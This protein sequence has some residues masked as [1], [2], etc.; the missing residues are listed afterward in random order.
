M[1]ILTRMSPGTLPASVRLALVA[2]AFMAAPQ[3]V[4]ADGFIVPSPPPHVTEVVPDLAV[5]YHHVE[6]T[7]KDQVAETQIDQVFVNDSAYELEGTYIFPLPEDAAIS[8]FA[9]FVDGRKW[10]GRVLDRDQARRIYEDI[11]RRRRDP[12]LLEYAG[13]DAFQASI[14]PIEPFGEKRVQLSYSQVLLSEDGLVRYVYPLST[15]QFSSRPLEEVVITIELESQIPIKAIYSPSHSIAVER[16]GERSALISFEASDVRPDEDFELYY[17][18]SEDDVS[19]S[20]LSYKERGEDGF[21]LLLIAPR[22][23]IREQAIVAKDVVFVLDTSGSMEGKKL[24]QAQEALQFVLDHLNDND[25]FNIIAFDTGVSKYASRLQPVSERQSAARF[26]RGLSAGGGTNIHRALLEAMEMDGGRRP[27]F[28]IFLTDGLPTAG[29]TDLNEIIAEVARTAPENLRLFAFGLGYDVNTVLLDTISQEHRG[30]SA[31]VEPGQSIEQEVSAFYTKI[32]SPLLSDVHL[33]VDGVVVED[34]YPYPLP[35]LFAGGQLLVAGRYR[36]G[37]K[38]SVTLEGMVNDQ[39]RRMSYPTVR[40]VSDGGSSFVPRLWATRKI[41]H[42]LQQIRLHG[43]NSELVDE[44]VSLSVRYGIMTPYTSF[45]VDES[46]DI[47]TEAG[48]QAVA[49]HSE[50]ATPMAMPQSGAKAVADSQLQSNLAES[51]RSDTASASEIAIV[52]SK[53]FVTRE[54]IWT[55]TTY[56]PDTMRPRQIAFGSP[57]YFKLLANHPEWGKYFAVGEQVIVV[58]DGVAHQVHPAQ[59]GNASPPVP[60][61]APDRWE[62]FV[63]WL[64]AI[65]K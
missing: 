12:A 62:D 50:L 16:S 52:A 7:I 5:K 35:D 47:L 27:Q 1:K 10:D 40:L 3:R 53:T 37:G 41:G 60:S 17:S 20:L 38:A 15:E 42:L 45:L 6:V 33:A 56:D 23:D 26:V 22:L 49:S 48:R 11:V 54:G 4:H 34:M 63:G 43:E 24:Q 28:I 58:L 65:L 29:E 13:R 51:I 59:S 2:C 21:F 55:D 25:R 18:V 64:R 32:S 9:M 61:S 44:I 36:T 8:D 30:A 46:Q 57:T 31:Y 19:L 39:R 14:Y